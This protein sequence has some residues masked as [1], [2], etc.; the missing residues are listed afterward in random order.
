MKHYWV[1]ILT[2]CNNKVLYTN[3]TN[4][5]NV[6]GEQNLANKMTSV[7][8]SKN[9]QFKTSNYAQGSRES[10]TG[11]LDAFFAGNAPQNSNENAGFTAVLEGN[12]DYATFV[13]SGNGKLSDRDKFDAGSLLPKESNGEWF[14]DPYE[15]TGIKSSKLINIYRPVGVNTIQTTLK[16]ASLDIRGSPPNPKYPVSPWNNSSYEPD[17]NIRSQ[18]LC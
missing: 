18:S 2:N 3:V 7:N 9:G 15:S 8:S 16:N 6:N 13:G 11:S 17:T 4:N 12:A 5:N 14:D 1:Y 10:S